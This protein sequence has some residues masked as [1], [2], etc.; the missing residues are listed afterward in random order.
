MTEDIEWRPSDESWNT[1]GKRDDHKAATRRQIQQATLDLMETAG[2]EATT[3]A[4]IAE[5]AGISER[6]FFRYYDSKESA[7]VPGQG[8]LLEALLSRDID[9]SAA[10]AEILRELIDACRQQFACEV[11]QVQFRRIS[12]LL[13]REPRLL[14]AVSRQEMHLV[15]TLSSTLTEPAL[16]TR[17]QAQLVA[18]L[19]AC[20]WRVAWQCFAREESA[21]RSSDPADL[22]EQA[23]QG[24]ADITAPAAFGR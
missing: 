22:F 7:A 5:R 18:E 10:P 24:L 6:T 11:E 21:G 19:V 1:V 3:V 8:E 13:L 2:V 15:D 23:V 4:S 16:L 9:P 17:M 14:Q 20:T 12:R